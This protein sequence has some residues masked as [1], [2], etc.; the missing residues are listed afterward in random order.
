MAFLF[1]KFKNMF[2]EKTGEDFTKNE[3]EYVIIYFANSNPK[4]SSKTIFY[5]TMHCLRAFYPLPVVKAMIQK[6]H[7]KKRKHQSVLKSFIKSLRK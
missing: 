3:K 7:F 4:S 1:D 6:K 2:K 5:S